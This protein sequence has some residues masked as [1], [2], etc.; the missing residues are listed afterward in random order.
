MSD[1][2]V[3]VWRQP[4]GSWRWRYL[5]VE[6]NRELRS[7]RG[8]DSLQDAVLSARQAYPGATVMA[9]ADRAVSLDGAPRRRA[10][11]LRIGAASALIVFA[12]LAAWAAMREAKRRKARRR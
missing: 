4:D 9:P 12:A 3:E 11:T 1:E 7:N 10:G 6:D 5:V 8:Y 2:L